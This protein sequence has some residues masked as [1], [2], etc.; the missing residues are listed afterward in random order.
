MSSSH[1][2]SIGK[3][4]EVKASNRPIKIAYLVPH[5]ETAVNHMV[6]DAVFHESYTRWAGAYTLVIPTSSGKFL[7][8]EYGAW[9]EFFDPDFVY[10]YV[11]LE[12]SLVETIDGLCSPISFLRHNTRGV[13]PDDRGWHA[14]LPDWG[15][16][17][18]AVS[19]VTMV[20]SPHAQNPSFMDREPEGEITIATQYPNGI[21]S[22]LLSDN[23]GTAFHPSAVTYPIPGLFRTLC[24][25]PPDLPKNHIAGTE[26][27]TSISEMLAAISSRKVLTIARFAMAHSETIP[28]VEPYRWAQSFNL[29][30]GSTL[31]DRVHFWNARQFTPSYAASLGSLV[32]EVEFFSDAESVIQL[33]QYLNKKN[34]LGQN[35]S[36]ARVSIRSYSYTEAE[37]LSIAE[38]LRKHTYNFVSV[39]KPFNIPVL[40]EEKDLREAYLR[41]SIDTTTF[42]LTED[43][44]TLTAKEPSHFAYLPPRLK[45]LATGQWIIELAIQRHNNLSK[46][47]DVDTWVLPKRRAIVRAFTRKLGKV[48]SRHRLAVLP[49]SE[50]FP[51]N[52]GSSNKE[53]SYS[54]SLPDDETFFRFLLLDIFKYPEDDVRVLLAR[55]A[56]DDLA[57]SD[58]G[59]NL[60][61]VISMFDNLSSA[62]EVL[63]NKYWREVLRA[64][65]E[66]SV[67]NLI[68][69]RGELESFLPNDLPTKEALKAKLHLSDVGKVRKYLMENLTDTLEY[70]I[71][72]NVFYYVHHWRC[73][74]CGHTNYRIFD[75]MKLKNSC[76]ICSQEYLAPIDLVWTYQLSEFVFRS[77]VTHSGLT[78]LWTLGYLQDRFGPESFWYIPEVDL[79][80]DHAAPEK[81]KEID[82]LCVRG[83]KF[84]AGEVKRSASQLTNQPG[85]LDSFVTKMNLIRPD[86]AIL[87]FERY[88]NPEEDIEAA[89]NSLRQAVNV[90]KKRMN[91]KIKLQI[92]V[93]CEDQGF[94]DQPAGLG[95]FGR[96]TR[97]MH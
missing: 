50:N 55:T 75:N 14:F 58:K 71:R 41:E 77:L 22:R 48:T 18:A 89:K 26:R 21:K 97:G 11:E 52:S 7:H 95:C 85:A 54:L 64:G 82:I 40:P 39:E 2:E 57:I 66:R 91:P 47:S 28:R 5:D 35:N 4:V 80:E 53:C 10:T 46:Y 44:N 59:Q 96:R 33:G 94:N 67:R 72:A 74:Y 9:L 81:K 37:L 25:V 65:N 29:F 17:F 73:K 36:P 31:L 88:C 83:G 34:Y 30:V 27:C 16:Y 76:E 60:R 23:F 69:S 61:G 20:P 38:K 3:T 1:F 42:K 78:V 45:G 12:A 32:L 87:S 93:A 68:F 51:F 43:T 24:L 84:I 13:S 49:V 15:I 8:S 92:I 19:S 79:Y 70:L 63:T 6:V 86:V 62:Y 90:V 56:Y